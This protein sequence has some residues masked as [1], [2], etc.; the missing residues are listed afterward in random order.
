MAYR[1][2]IIPAAGKAARFGG[3]LKE[4]L[5]L[6]N[7]VSFIAESVLRL[8]N[9]CDDIVVVTS[10]EKIR[11]H[12]V[13][14]GGNVLYAIQE[15]KRDIW[16]AMVTGMQIEA[17]YYLFTMPDTYMPRDSFGGYQDQLFAM[18]MHETNTPERF[19][20]LKGSKIVNKCKDVETPV[21]AWGVLA[22]AKMA[23]QYWLGADIQTYTD[24]INMALVFSVPRF[25]RLDFYHDNATIEDYIS[26][27][28]K[29]LK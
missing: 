9:Y 7:G 11:D 5:P 22:W 13:E 29:D 14:L 12:A 16:G 25:W 21:Q 3:V 19:G 8:R 2:G 23:K 24:A 28:R 6:P 18:G 27:L 17:D 1:L 15:D 20:C 10:P 26:L 4:L